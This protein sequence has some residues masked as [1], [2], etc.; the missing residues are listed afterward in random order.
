MVGLI[1]PWLHFLEITGIM[2][3]NTFLQVIVAFYYPSPN[4]C[5]LF[6]VLRQLLRMI[7]RKEI[8]P[9]PTELKTSNR[10]IPLY[11]KQIWLQKSIQ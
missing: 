9:K 3:S 2:T 1:E 7:K 6:S 8:P 5:T 11:I 10:E 4:S